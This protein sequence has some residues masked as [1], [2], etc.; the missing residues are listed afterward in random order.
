MTFMSGFEVRERPTFEKAADQDWP[1]TASFSLRE[2]GYADTAL[3]AVAKMAPLGSMPP[4]PGTV[5]VPDGTPEEKVDEVFVRLVDAQFPSMKAKLS[6]RIA[7]EHPEIAAKDV[8][9][10]CLRY[11]VFTLEL[12]GQ[13]RKCGLIY[14]AKAK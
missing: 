8:S 9:F 3:Y 4:D 6:E 14:S 12:G 11:C 1:D 5:R 13:V 10:Y 2:R 7:K